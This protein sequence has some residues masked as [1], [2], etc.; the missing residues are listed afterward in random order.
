MTAWLRGEPGW[1]DPV[2]GVSKAR[3]KLSSVA[4][5]GS[6]LCAAEFVAH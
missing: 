1:F 4:A 2:G 3:L 6:A 5:R